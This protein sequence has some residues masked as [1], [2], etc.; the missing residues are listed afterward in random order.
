MR[1]GEPSRTAAYVAVWRALGDTLPRELRLTHDPYGWLFAPAEVRWLRRV[2]ERFPTATGGVL[3]HSPLR[4]LLIWM[5]LRTRAIDELTLDFVR[6]GGRQLV[7]LGAGFDCRALRL[8]EALAGVRCLE[9]DHP[10]TQA[11][12]RSLLATEPVG[13]AVAYVAWDF[14]R[15][16]LDGLPARLAEQGLRPEAPTLTLWEGVI[17]YLSEAAVQATLQA[18]RSFG[19]PGS[20][21][22][23]HYIER[24][25]IES[26]TIWHRAARR[27]GEPLRF[28]WEP[29][30]L[31][32]W[33]EPRGFELL[34]D[35]D[36]VALAAAL[37]P[38]LWREDSHAFRGAG[39][40]IA[41]ARSR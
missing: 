8:R 13:D 9:V 40:R 39:G 32:Q 26:D 31:P 33:L 6:A 10:A 19:A 14:E 27:V 7:L 17:P 11:H 21:V 2:A 29:G 41:V 12:K 23:L 34:E 37:L 36:D 18:V 22:V 3:L 38:G 5:Q 1:D 15:D 28:G 35:R 20:P 4:R 24:L 25:R 16:A 30:A